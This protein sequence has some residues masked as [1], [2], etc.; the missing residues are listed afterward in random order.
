MTAYV[1]AFFLAAPLPRKSHEELLGIAAVAKPRTGR[2]PT[3]LSTSRSSS[4]VVAPPSSS[5]AASTSTS[6]STRDNS[7]IVTKSTDSLDDDLDAPRQAISTTSGWAS[8]PGVDP[9]LQPTTTSPSTTTLTAAHS[10]TTPTTTPATPTTA[11][12]PT[13]S[14]GWASASGAASDLRPSVALL[15]NPAFSTTT[16]SSHP[17]L[18]DALLVNPAFSLSA[19]TITP[20]SFLTPVDLNHLLARVAANLEEQNSRYAQFELDRERDLGLHRREAKSLRD[21]H[22]QDH[23]R[24]AVT[25]PSVKS[26]IKFYNSACKH[27]TTCDIEDSSCYEPVLDNTAA[28]VLLKPMPLRPTSTGHLLKPM[29]HDPRS[30]ALLLTP[31]TSDP[32]S[33]AVLWRPI[34]PTPTASLTPTTNQSHSNLT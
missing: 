30:T 19:P 18:L 28:G 27:S 6:S 15:G 24:Q 3:T 34:D 17:L 14:L 23:P 32:T 8:A 26:R 11:P 20:T 7:E 31:M 4:P 12:A 2:S 16:A 22:S 13:T 25:F 21:N 29:L 10:T 9:A 33:P 1:E 5:R